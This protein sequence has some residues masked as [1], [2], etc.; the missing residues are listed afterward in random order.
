MLPCQLVSAAIRCFFIYLFKSRFKNGYAYV[1][2]FGIWYMWGL[3]NFIL[4]NNKILLL[5]NYI[6][7]IRKHGFKKTYRDFRSII[8]ARKT[9]IKNH[10][11]LSRR[12]RASQESMVF[13]KN[14]KISLIVSLFNAPENYLKDMIESVEKQTYSNYELVMVDGS[15]KNHSY[16]R[17]ICR[18]YIKNN[19][20]IKY[21]KVSKN[22]G[23]SERLNKA[24]ESASGAYI[25]LLH[26]SDILHHGA[27][28]EVMRVISFERADFIYTDE[29]Y[30][31]NNYIL[32][33]RH[34][35]PDYAIDTLCSHNYISHLTVFS[36][37]IMEK[38]GVFRS[39]YDGSQDYD[40]ILR[41]TD[42]AGKICHIPKLL[43]FKRDD[44]KIISS[45]INRILDNIS[46][47]E[48]V[49][50]D[51]LIKREKPARVERKIE[52]PGYFRVV[53][54][55][56]ET[57]KVSIIIP[58]KDSSSLLRK[59]ISSIINKTTYR[60]YEIIIVENNSKEEAVFAF[61]EELKRYKNIRVVYWKKLGFNFS[62]ISNFGVEN[63]TGEQLLFLNNDITI[64]SPGWIEE[65]LMYS[66]RSDVGAVG[67]K[68]Y[69]PN[70]SIQHAGV[71]LGIGKI[72]SHIYQS[73]QH[74]AVGYM[75]KLQI[76]QNLS[77]V[78]AACMM[79]KKYIFD[80][81]GPFAPEFP[82]SFNDVDLCLKIRKAGY[83]I[84]WTPYAEA[85]HLESRTRGYN[86]G[87]KKRLMLAQ[88]VKLF[89]KRWYKEL[90]AGDTYYN[91]NF[92]LEKSDY[93]YR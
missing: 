82:N 31:K 27:L 15:D 34:H 72:A 86:I 61:Y 29:A 13:H 91:V 48:R 92:S 87:S 81:V 67:A 56:K 23:V 76:V 83:L 25:G 84:V 66:Q 5:V 64:I 52:L 24:I 80:E 11:S 62:E 74:H 18:N 93:S 2:S 90:A 79:V 42:I 36:R 45:N 33:L 41:Y 39:E 40:L 69:Y 30:F 73:V 75:G 37:K 44:K 54:D 59:C 50:T 19:A 17:Q 65:M 55:L 68:L 49:L 4:R 88:D 3:V 10:I 85:Y 22:T 47:T 9:Y 51:Y 7:S 53:Y 78:T 26:Q 8:L 58:N 12:E 43:Y 57:P 32:S 63:S 60:N 35:K 70:G 46:T 89:R 21:I 14:Y 28:Y 20:R 16:V 77:V 71:I 1:W 38:A 6:R